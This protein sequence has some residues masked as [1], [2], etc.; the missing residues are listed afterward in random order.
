MKETFYIGAHGNVSTHL[1]T[2]NLKALAAAESLAVVEGIPIGTQLIGVR[3]VTD[4][5]GDNTGIKLELVDRHQTATELFSMATTSAKQGAKV[6]KPVYVS[7]SGPSD[8]VLTNT[9]SGSAAGEVHIQ[10]E[11]RFKG[12]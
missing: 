1:V 8:V 10:L 3:Y 12:Y 5:L 9:G 4:D 6:I 11:Y 2:L 7:D